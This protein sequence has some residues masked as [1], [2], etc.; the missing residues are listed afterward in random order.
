VTRRAVVERVRGS[1]PRPS[2][3]VRAVRLPV[4]TTCR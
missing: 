4:S 3:L 1:R 2:Y